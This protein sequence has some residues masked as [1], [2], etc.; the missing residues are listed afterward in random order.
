M[1]DV[2]EIITTS[3]TLEI[4]STG[5]PGPRGLQGEQGDPGPAG[6]PATSWQLVHNGT[7]YDITLGTGPT[8]KITI[9]PA[10]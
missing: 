10:S 9:T 5:A 2:L 1:A 8:P 7:T 4:P 3:Q 6:P